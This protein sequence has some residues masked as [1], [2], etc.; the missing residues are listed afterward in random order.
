MSTAALVFLPQRIRVR[1]REH[2]LRCCLG[3]LQVEKSHSS[4]LFSGLTTP[5]LYQVPSSELS[6]VLN[7]LDK[8]SEFSNSYTVSVRES[9]CVANRAHAKTVALLAAC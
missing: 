5:K 1:I 3:D 8:L 4:H 9:V 2:G 7:S 6:S